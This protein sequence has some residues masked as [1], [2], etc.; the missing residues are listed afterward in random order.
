MPSRRRTSASALPSGA[1]R[2]GAG[3]SALDERDFAAEATYRL[4]HLDA[5]RPSAEHEQPA[6]HGLHPGHLPVR[7]DP[8]SPR[9]PGIGGMTGSAPFART[10]WSAVWRTPSTST[11][12]GPARR[13][14]PRNRSM[15]LSASQR[16]WP[17]S[18]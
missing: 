11:T 8:S 6:R 14:V 3:A 7:P 10:T 18:E 9:R 12:P 16:S 4:R 17:A 15:P 13:P 1:A 2:A 5:D